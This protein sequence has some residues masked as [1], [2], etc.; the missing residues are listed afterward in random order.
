M[1]PR[2]TQMEMVEKKVDIMQSTCSTILNEYHYH[3]A[4][5]H[6]K[7]TLRVQNTANNMHIDIQY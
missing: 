4:E 2:M 6:S 7:C 5:R 3:Q 1:H